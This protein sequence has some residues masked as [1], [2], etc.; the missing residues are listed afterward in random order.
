MADPFPASWHFAP[1]RRL[2]LSRPRV[3][4]IFNITPDSFSD[5][6]ENLDTGRALA[7]AGQALADGASILD[8]GGESTRPGAARI[9][10]DEQIARI[11]PLIRAIRRSSSD[12]AQIPISIDTTLAPV[13]RA[14][15][16]AGADAIN[17]V[18]AG[19]EDPAIFALAAERCAGIIL[20]HR[21]HQPQ[22]DSYSDRYA[23][24]PQYT[25]VVAEVREFLQQRIA[26]A[27]HAGIPRQAIMI[28]PGLGF[29]KTVEQ[30]LEL[31]RRNAEFASL[32]S[33]ILSAASRKSFVGR[34]M[35]LEQSLPADRLPGSLAITIMH[36]AA[37]ARLFRVHDVRPQV[38]A[39]AA[40]A[41][42]AGD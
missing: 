18:A 19:L 24:Q 17:D 34:A 1:G 10:A 20:M 31:I 29:G 32:G 7:A 2:D 23:T 11:V 33:P 22:H 3:M 26:A 15:I 16:D 4:A 21:L 41:A 28:D 36:Y 37:G 40:A 13:A 35:G 12:L 6:G 5:G 27:M 8:I 14:A 39:L 9:P 42:V 30:N 25:D 38:Q